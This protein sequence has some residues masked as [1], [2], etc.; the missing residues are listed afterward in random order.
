[1]LKVADLFCGMGGLSFGFS[2]AG[3]QVKAYDI[4]KHV[5]DIFKQNNIG[6]AEITDLSDT[7]LYL[8]SDIIIGGPPCRP[9]SSVN[10]TRRKKEH[11][12]YGLVESF[13]KI[14]LNSEPD[15]F[16]MENV[17]PVR[18]DESY[19]RCL[20]NMQEKYS[21]G[22]LL[23]RYSDFGAATKRRRLITFGFKNLNS[24]IFKDNLEKNKKIP[25]KVGDVLEPYLNYAFK[26]FPDHEW[27]QLKTIKK[28]K[29]NYETGKFGWYKLKWDE[30]APSF[31]NIMKTYTL[32][33]FAGENF[34]VRVISVREAMAIMG[35]PSTFEFPLDMGHTIKYQMVA[36]AV[37]PIFSLSCASAI[38]E[39]LK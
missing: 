20:N 14:V 32:H 5:P 26:E 9:W 34:P 4:N 39:T 28:Y 15:V 7:D 6:N 30:P 25:L 21:V 10:V 33:P 16:L 19:V 27:P 11:P 17:P 12:E 35:F 13:F 38:R 8:D 37:S 2:K 29:K 23:V 24:N 31:G 3:F 18:N 36:D 22:N 1:M